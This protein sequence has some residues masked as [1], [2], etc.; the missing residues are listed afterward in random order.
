MQQ[1]W[2]MLSP[3]VWVLCALLLWG[4]SGGA[5]ANEGGSFGPHA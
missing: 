2:D 1:Y 4:C 3:F 5:Y